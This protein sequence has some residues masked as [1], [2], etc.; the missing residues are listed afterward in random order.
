[1]SK[2][3]ESDSRGTRSRR[4]VLSLVAVGCV[5]A[6]TPAWGQ[7]YP[8]R[9]VKLVVPQAAGGAADLL[10]RLLA[11][12]LSKASNQTVVVEN[13]VGAGT[14]MGTDSVA[15]AAP[16][17]YTLLMG[18]FAMAVLPGIDSKLPFDPVKDLIPVVQI[19]DVPSVLLVNKSVPAQ[20]LKELIAY[21]KANPGK[22][23]F[24]SQGLAT[25]GHMKGE[26]LKQ[27][28][29]IDITHV[30]YRGSA[31]AAQDLIAGHVHMLFQ[32]VT[33]AASDLQN[34]SIRAIAITS[35]KRSPVL[36]NVPTIAEAGM[37]AVESSVWFG[38]FAPAGTP[39]DIVNWLNTEANKIFQTPAVRDRLTAQGMNLPLGTAAAFQQFVASESKRWVE[40]AQRGNIKAN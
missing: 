13:R 2:I 30:P 4:D 1:M 22:L 31:P 12:G 19:A 28:A 39:A 8:S 16:D 17:G 36:P 14:V 33:L 23:S 18:T 25:S 40:V 10:G 32:T 11:D 34:D 38:L 21:A 3:A 24:A 9:T 7:A 37:P 26:L 5:A 29:G 6:V 27:T 15:K 20:S 35:A